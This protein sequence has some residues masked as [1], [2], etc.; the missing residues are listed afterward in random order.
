MEQTSK[1]QTFCFVCEQCSFN[2]SA[3]SLVLLLL[4]TT[5]MIGKMRP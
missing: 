4:S 2:L 1:G 5:S 3:I